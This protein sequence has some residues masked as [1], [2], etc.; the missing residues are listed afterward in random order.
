[1]KAHLEDA[2]T[3]LVNGEHR[4][5]PGDGPGDGFGDRSAPAP[6]EMAA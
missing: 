5:G 4:M 3:A 2:V 6:T 1:M